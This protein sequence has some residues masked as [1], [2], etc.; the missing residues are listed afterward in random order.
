MT[1]IG[2]P[3]FIFESSENISIIIN[4]YEIG[5]LRMFRLLEK[6]IISHVLDKILFG[7]TSLNIEEFTIKKGSFLFFLLPFT[8]C[9]L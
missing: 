8:I 9:L 1:F 7:D 3:L 4:P 5:A 2:C 6:P